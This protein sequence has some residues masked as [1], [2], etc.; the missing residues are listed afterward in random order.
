MGKITGELKA[1]GAVV[2]AISNEG[3]GSLQQMKT[4]EGL[5]DTFVFLSDVD[6]KA[7]GNYAGHY[8]DQGTLKPATY[9]IDKSGNIAFAYQGED[10][11]V[12]A[13]AQAVL[14]AVQ[15]SK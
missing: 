7:A 9:V 14:A 15:K 8:A 11:K 3:P 13:D 4:A 2:Y 12:R 10:Y 6:A 1:A 5:D